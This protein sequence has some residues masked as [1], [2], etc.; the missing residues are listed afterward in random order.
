[1]NSEVIKII[2]FV[3]VAIAEDNI[4]FSITQLQ[5]HDKIIPCQ[6]LTQFTLSKRMLRWQKKIT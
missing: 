4:V 3:Q 6:S 5:I 2:K 1:M